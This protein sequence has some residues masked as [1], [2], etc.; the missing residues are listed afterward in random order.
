ME[1]LQEFDSRLER[2]FSQLSQQAAAMP[3]R[4]LRFL[5]WRYGPTSPHAKREI[6]I[7]TD[8]HGDLLGYVVFYA[9]SATHTGLVLDVLTLPQAGADVPVAL[10]RHAVERLRAEGAWIVRYYHFAS[11]RAIPPSFLRRMGFIRRGGHVLL[12]KFADPGLQAVASRPGA[13]N[14]SFGDSEASHALV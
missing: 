8:G 2:F 4:D 10:M 1:P 3:A 14:Y 12:I 6:G 11:P 9:S 7:V 13:W 5:R